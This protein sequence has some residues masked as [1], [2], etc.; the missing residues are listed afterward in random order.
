MN[1][2]IRI[3]SLNIGLKSD[4]AGVLTLISVH[5][6]DLI[7]LQEVRIT[8]EQINQQ[9]GNHGFKGMVNIDEEDP[10]R[11]GTALAWRSTLPIKQVSAVVPCRVQHALLGSYSIF[12]IYAPSGSD[13][14]VE[15]GLFFAREVFQAFAIGSSPWILGGD[16]NCVLEKIDIENGTGFNQKKCPQLSDLVATKNLRDIF[17]HRNPRTKEFTFFRTNCAPSRLDRFYLSHECLKEVKLIEHVASLSDHCGVL[18]DMR[19]QNVVFSKIKSTSTTYWKLNTRILKDEDFLEN[20]AAL[21]EFLKLKQ[22][23]FSDIADWWNE[24]AKPNIKDFCIAFSSQRN[25]RRMDTKAFWLAYLKL[26]LIHK[27]WTEVARVKG[28]LL[29][30]MQEDA[31]GFVVRSRF[32]NSVSEETASIF[33]ANKEMKNAAKNNIKAL[34]MGNI[35]SEDEV[36]IEEEITKFFRALFNGHHSTSLED[37]GEPF[38]ADNSEINYFLQDLSTLPDN[39]RDNLV[40]EIRMEELEEIIG[41]CKNNKSPGLDG[42][43]YEFYLETFPIIKNDLV[44]ILQCQLD[45]SKI[46][47]SNKDGVTRLAPKVNGVP[48]V[49]ELRPITLLNCDYKI[50]SKWLVKRMK[51]VLPYVIRSGQLCTVGKKNI[52]FGVTNILSSILDVKQRNSQACLI[53]LDFFKAYDRVFLKFLVKVMEKMN[54]G[55]LFTSWITMLHEGATTRFIISGLTRAIRLL[56]SIRQ[57]D[58]IAMLLYIIYVEPLLLALEKRMTGLK[59]ADIGKSLEAYCDD[60]NVITD[61]LGDFD[62]VATAIEKFEKVSGAILSRNKKC[63]VIGF[64]NWVDK[65]D[66][67]LEWVKP[68]KFEKIF[69][70]FICDSYNEVLELNWNYRFNKFN[71]MIYSW[72]H[73][74]LDTLQQRVEVIRMFGLSRVYYVAAVLPM[75]PNVVKKFESLIGKYIWNF[76]GRVLRVAID[77]LKNKKVKGGLNLPCLASMADSLLFSQL[78]RLIKSG[79]KKTLGHASYWLGDLLQSLAPDINL[80]QRR[81]PVT[82]EY[83]GYI[84]D[85]LAEMMINE[86]VSAGTMKSLTNKKVYAE[87]TSSFPPPKVVRE[88]NRDY[89]SAWKRLHSPVVDVRARDVL[90]LLLHNKLPVKERLFRIGLKHDPYCLKCAGAEVNDIVHFFCTCEAVCNTWAWLKSQVVQLGHMGAGVDDWDLINLLFLHSSRDAE[91]VWLVSY[92]VLYVWEMMYVKRVEVKLDKFF[93]YLTFKYKMYQ[94]TSP[95][96][97][98]NLHYT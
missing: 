39:E 9:L 11:P 36:A 53:T 56:F 42:L 57:G 82:P 5:K 13:K 7:L 78:C 60:I 26:V 15:R 28:M 66:W 47:E 19:F 76:S 72:S 43:C 94:A 77:D 29:G 64:G 51:P 8:D 80:G 52:L 44:H 67:P 1:S 89:S 50:L 38:E 61:N 85:L 65:E 91:I 79:E 58:P 16:F 84:A 46:I 71:N 18:L 41:E 59:V 4:L 73:R 83:F 33:H 3:L 34:K 93:G 55:T 2:R 88:S 87:I 97:P 10:L 21:W 95:K 40:K 69:G 48:S 45:R 70:I 92:Y 68:V 23:N 6:L 81:A 54:F 30:M 49:D 90:F 20:F 32:H 17:R 25:M 86:K 62:V 22:N 27:N 24:E 75:K 63:K 35:V 98:I 74:V 12:N 96:Q 14:K 37:T 31:Y